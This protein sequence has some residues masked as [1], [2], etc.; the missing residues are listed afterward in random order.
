[1]ARSSGGVNTV[2]NTTS[3]GRPCKLNSATIINAT[4]P[5]NTTAPVIANWRSGAVQPMRRART[6]AN[7][8][9][10]SR[11]NRTIR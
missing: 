4:R 11:A 1:M 7:P 2:A 3:G 5:A 9:M 10:A 6:I 8:S